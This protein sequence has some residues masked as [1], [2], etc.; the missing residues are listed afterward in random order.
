MFFDDK[1]KAP[2]LVSEKMSRS[3][4]WRKTGNPRTPFQRVM[5]SEST[6]VEESIKRKLA[7]Q[8]EGLNPFVLR[9]AIDTRIRKVS[10]V[11]TIRR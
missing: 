11:N 2:Y 5:E 7:R 4:F 9:K 8:L 3:V 6:H 1:N 10:A